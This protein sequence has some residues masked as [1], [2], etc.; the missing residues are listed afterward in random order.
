[1]S[2]VNI[3]NTLLIYEC[4]ARHSVFFSTVTKFSLITRQKGISKYYERNMSVGIS[5]S[6]QTIMSKA[7][8]GICFCDSGLSA[9]Q[10]KTCF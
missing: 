7:I 4:L 3:L 9:K 5:R 1:M 10:A 2:I 8:S 6:Y